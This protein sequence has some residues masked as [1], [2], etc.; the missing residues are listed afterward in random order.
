[1]K[2]VNVRELHERTG[3]IVDLATK[4]RVVTIVKRG[5]PVAELRP[6]V[7]SARTRTLPDRVALLAR[8]PKLR[9]DSGRFLEEDRS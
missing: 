2:Q 5:R 3:A 4:G 6:L 7:D 1:M 8:Y 9:G